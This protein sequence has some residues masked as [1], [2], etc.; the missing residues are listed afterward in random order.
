[1]TSNPNISNS[2]GKVVLNCATEGASLGYKIVPKEG[3]TPEVWSV[4]QEP[5]EI[6]DGATVM[7]QAYRIGFEPSEVVAIN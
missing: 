1:V 5:F 7:A 2:E 3:E 6:P 4:Y